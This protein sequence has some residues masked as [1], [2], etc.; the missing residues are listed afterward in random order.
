MREVV[1]AAGHVV[2][3]M[4]AAAGGRA[5]WACSMRLR[6]WEMARTVLGEQSLEADSFIDAV[7][8]DLSALGVVEGRPAAVEYRAMHWLRRSFR[9]D[10]SSLRALICEVEAALAL[11][12]DAAAGWDCRAAL[13]Q[14][15]RMASNY[16]GGRGQHDLAIEFCERALRIETATLGGMHASTAGTIRS[17]GSSYCEKGQYDRA[18]ELFERALRI[19]TATLGEMHAQTAGT[20]CSMGTSYGYKGQYDLAIELFERALRI[21][22]ATLGEMHAETA[23]TI[24]SMGTLYNKKGQYDQAIELFERALR[25]ETAMLGEMHAQTAG[26]I[27][28]MGVSY[29]KK[30]QY[31]RAI[32]L[33]ERAL[34][35]YHQ[36]LGPHHPET[37]QTEQSLAIIRSA[38]G[39]QIT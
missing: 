2:G 16:M 19:E 22:T 6:V 10:E 26:A 34:R 31:D 35:I 36:A 21:Q 4:K 14:A 37:Q 28:S 13:S 24:C 5:A 8:A 27:R 17:M 32:E 9:G 1:G 18:I 38:A 25:I 33:F 29:S 30:G 3:R 12:P 23:A 7:D 20:I 11:A 15:E 39:R